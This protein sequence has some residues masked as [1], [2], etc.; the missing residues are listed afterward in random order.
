[1][2]KNG[3]QLVVVSILNSEHGSIETRTMV[4]LGIT[5]CDLHHEKSKIG[6]N[7]QTEERANHSKLTKNVL[8]L[9]HLYFQTTAD[10]LSYQNIVRVSPFSEQKC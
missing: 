7:P 6:Q 2:Q 8:I 10:K 5:W 3:M 9:E 1:M 4:I